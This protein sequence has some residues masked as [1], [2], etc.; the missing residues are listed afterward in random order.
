M[1]WKTGPE[2]V[3]FDN[4]YYQK[5][6]NH[7][8]Q[9][10]IRQKI[11]RSNSSLPWLD[12]INFL[13]NVEDIEDEKFDYGEVE[14]YTP[15]LNNYDVSVI[16]E[17]RLNKVLQKPIE[18]VNNIKDFKEQ[19]KSD[20]KR[21]FIGID[22]TLSG[23]SDNSIGFSINIPFKN[24]EDQKFYYRPVFLLAKKYGLTVSDVY[25]FKGK[26]K[27]NIWTSIKLENWP[28]F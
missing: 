21:V 28:V 4:T 6:W 22:C 10:D 14:I 15:T 8:N 3:F 1:N 9:V 17:E 20:I 27:D 25:L 19:I 13:N 23:L 5:L 7:I 24:N 12:L 11:E 18:A 16:P 2:Q 26:N